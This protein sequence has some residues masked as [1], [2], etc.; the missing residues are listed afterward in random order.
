MAKPSRKNRRSSGERRL[1]RRLANVSLGDL[2]ESMAQELEEFYKDVSVR[3]ATSRQPACGAPLVPPTAV[4]RARRPMRRPAAP[5]RQ[6]AAARPSLMTRRTMRSGKRPVRARNAQTIRQHNGP[7]LRAPNR[8]H[9]WIARR[10]AVRTSGRLR[11][12]RVRRRPPSRRRTTPT[13]LRATPI[14]C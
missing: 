12:R 4:A 10:R 13:S 1:H 2:P 8:R 6:P 7:M 14:P 11:T 9:G 5:P 3:Y